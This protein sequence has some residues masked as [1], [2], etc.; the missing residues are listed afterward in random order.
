MACLPHRTV[1]ATEWVVNRDE[2]VLTKDRAGGR[3]PD[4][5][6]QG[7]DAARDPGGGEVRPGAALAN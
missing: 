6:F 1:A 5:V 4:A 7:T 2:A 3:V